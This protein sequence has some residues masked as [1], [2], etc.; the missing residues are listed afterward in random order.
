MRGHLVVTSGFW[1]ILGPPGPHI[2]WIGPI[3][4]STYS[5]SLENS[6]PTLLPLSAL[7]SYLPQAQIQQWQAPNQMTQSTSSHD[8]QK[9]Q[10]FGL[11]E[12]INILPLTSEARTL[13]S[14]HN[15]SARLFRLTLLRS[16]FTVF[17]NFSE[18]LAE[19]SWDFFWSM[20]QPE[21]QAM[22]LSKSRDQIPRHPLA[23]VIKD[24][25]EIL[26]ILRTPTPFLL[27]AID[28]ATRRPSDITLS[29]LQEWYHLF[30]VFL[31]VEPWCTCCNISIVQKN[32]NV[33]GEVSRLRY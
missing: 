7:T 14:L 27:H 28:R 10:Y 11:F 17:V 23:T 25:I 18:K 3:S 16:I 30:P 19:S 32:N 13:L 20:R 12:H 5:W 15:C 21:S 29:I 22:P 2:E 1:R 24:V 9:R 6:P 26:S 33:F 31:A 8:K 4:A